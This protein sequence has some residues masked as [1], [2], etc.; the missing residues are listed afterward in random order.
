MP[1]VN[2]ATPGKVPQ[3]TNRRGVATA[4]GKGERA[5]QQRTVPQGLSRYEDWLGVP[6]TKVLG[7]EQCVDIRQRHITGQ[8]HIISRAAIEI[9]GKRIA[10]Q[11]IIARATRDGDARNT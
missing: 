10:D 5:R 7:R 1:L 3:K 8:D 11:H 9:I 6:K 4:R 2:G